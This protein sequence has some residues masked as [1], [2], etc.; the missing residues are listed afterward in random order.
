MGEKA[1]ETVY[2]ILRSRGYAMEIPYGEVGMFMLATSTTMY[3]HRKQL[4][5]NGILKKVVRL[6][7]GDKVPDGVGIPQ[8]LEPRKEWIHHSLKVFAAGYCIKMIPGF[9]LSLPKIFSNPKLILRA[10]VNKDNAR[11]GAFTGSLILLFRVFE[12]VSYKIRRKKDEWNSFLAGGI[13]GL[14]MLFQRS[15]T[16][17]LYVLSKV[18][19]VLYF[20]GAQKGYLPWFKNGDVFLYTVCT[21]VMFHAAVLEPHNLNPTYWRF[22]S[23]LT[24]KRFGEMNRKRLDPFGLESSR[25]FPDFDPFPLKKMEH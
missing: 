1:I 5:P 17:A 24:N 2:N 6:L 20:R 7:L 19:E 9:L 12:Y 8:S 3:L 14:S 21:A 18:G 10:L 4:L 16:L 23:N 22:L 25:C 13:A 15:S 11:F